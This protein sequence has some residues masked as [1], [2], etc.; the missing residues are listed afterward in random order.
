[1]PLLKEDVN[2]TSTASSG[3]S[4]QGATIV[5]EDGSTHTITGKTFNMSTCNSPVTVYPTWQKNTRQL[6][7]VDA[8]AFNPTFSQTLVDSG[9]TGTCYNSAGPDGHRYYLKLSDTDW[10]RVQMTSTSAIDLTDYNNMNINAW[11]TDSNT[12]IFFGITKSRSTWLQSPTGV[13]NADGGTFSYVSSISSN[14]MAPNTFS[15]N[16]ENYTGNWYI[17]VQRLY[18]GSKKNQSCNANYITLT[19]KTYSYTNRGL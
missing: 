17:A 5:C 13:E 6:F 15:C 12:R 4:Y 3:F 18:T 7:R 19:G 8:Q 14:S 11:C 2:I 10:S 16:I 9:G 1:M